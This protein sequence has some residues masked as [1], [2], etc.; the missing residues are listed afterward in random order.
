MFLFRFLAPPASKNVQP[1]SEAVICST[2]QKTIP[3]IIFFITRRT[4]GNPAAGEE[5]KYGPAESKSTGSNFSRLLKINF[6]YNND[7]KKQRRSSGNAY[8]IDTS[9]RADG[10]NTSRSDRAWKGPQLRTVCNTD[11]SLNS[12]RRG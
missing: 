12:Y 3:V 10:N 8:N 9:D 1:Q 2:V 11:N 6:R 7:T 5:L 4:S